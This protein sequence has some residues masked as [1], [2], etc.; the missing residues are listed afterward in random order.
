MKAPFFGLHVFLHSFLQSR[1]LA[2]ISITDFSIPSVVSLIVWRWWAYFSFKSWCHMKVL[3]THYKG[4]YFSSSIYS[5]TFFSRTGLRLNAIDFLVTLAVRAIMK[6][7]GYGD[8][9]RPYVWPN[10]RVLS[11]CNICMSIISNNLLLVQVFFPIQAHFRR[12][13]SFSSSS[14]W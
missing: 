5:F 3:C 13:T 10:T 6:A 1:L 7:E 9:I 11:G 8:I 12:L 2:I 14:I 4:I